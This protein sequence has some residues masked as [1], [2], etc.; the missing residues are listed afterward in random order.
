MS[1][2]AV[3]V[4]VP[5]YKGEEHLAATI[6]SVL[7]QTFTD[8]EL[9]VLD[10]AS[11]DRSG[12]IAAS[13]D[14]PRIRLLTNPSVLPLTENWNTAVRAARAPLVKLLPDDDLL[15]PRCLELQVAA[16]A[17]DPG[18]AVVMARRHLV[19]GHG[20]MIVPG[21]SLRGLL[22]PRTR[23]QVLRRVVRSGANPLGATCAAT[24]RRTAFDAT[25]GF[26]AEKVFVADLDLLVALTAHGGFL[27]QRAAL[28]G[29]RVVPTAVFAEAGRAQ[30]R[31]QEELLHDLAAAPESGV[32]WIDTALGRLGARLAWR[33]R[34][35][36]ERLAGRA[37]A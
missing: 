6:D 33:R 29:Y 37:S 13:Y 30:F 23:T 25:D 31:V 36:A 32:R 24:F 3:S 14:D 4:C 35:L 11:P 10:N 9:V 27:G 20:R 7:A 34:H 26:S 19:D 16:L 28:A 21:V 22:G 17:A 18:L 5:V 12:E 15:H 2:P 8:F 1:G